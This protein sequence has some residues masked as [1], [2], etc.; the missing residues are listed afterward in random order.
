MFS[1]GGPENFAYS[2]FL[3]NLYSLLGEL[4]PK[5][6]AAKLPKHTI[7]FLK[8]TVKSTMREIRLKNHLAYVING[9]VRIVLDIPHASKDKFWG[10]TARQNIAN[11]A[12]ATIVAEDFSNL[13]EL[14]HMADMKQHEVNTLFQLASQSSTSLPSKPT[15]KMPQQPQQA[16]QLPGCLEALSGLQTRS[17]IPPPPPVLGSGNSLLHQQL[18]QANLQQQQ[19]AGLLQQQQAEL[20]QL[21]HQH[22]EH[23]QQHQAGLLQQQQAEFLQQQ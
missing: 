17:A 18:L 4:Y 6:K 1:P 12:K 9:T 19:Q 3:G 8:F 20:P 5:D 2:F 7:V 13:P 15:T 10:F 21:Q 11:I 14:M 22:A 16:P 23:L